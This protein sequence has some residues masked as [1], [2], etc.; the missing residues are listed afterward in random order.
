[1]E[2][3]LYLDVDNKIRLD[4]DLTHLH[5]LLLL[6]IPYLSYMVRVCLYFY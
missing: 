2:S 1:M 6:S 3:Q 5:H 4:K